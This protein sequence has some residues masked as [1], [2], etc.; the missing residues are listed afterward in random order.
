MTP[1]RLPEVLVDARNLISLSEHILAENLP[2]DTPLLEGVLLV[3][4]TALEKLN[5]ASKQIQD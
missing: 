3:I 5:Q 1:D 4:R 2:P